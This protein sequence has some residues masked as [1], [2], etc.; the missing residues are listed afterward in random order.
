MNNHVTEANFEQE[1]LQAH[2]P[3]LVDFWADWFVAD[4]IVI[5]GQRERPV[6]RVDDLVSRARDRFALPTL[7]TGRALPRAA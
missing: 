6:R 4:E 3:V 2:G 7:R 5:A 1:V